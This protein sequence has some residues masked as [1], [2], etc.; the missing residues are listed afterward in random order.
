MRTESIRASIEASSHVLAAAEETSRCARLQIRRSEA[1]LKRLSR[2]LPPY[3]QTLT[4]GAHGP[5]WRAPVSCSIGL[6]D[7]FRHPGLPT[8]NP[9][10]ILL[11]EPDPDTAEMYD[12][13]LRRSRD[14]L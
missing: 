1:V 6:D 14:A 11:I 9:A 3:A 7:M 5:G 12:I 10:S 13:G 8:A 4:E 2:Y